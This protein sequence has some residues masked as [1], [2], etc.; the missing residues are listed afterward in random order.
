MIHGLITLVIVLVMYALKLP[1]ELYWLPVL[2]YL[3]REHAQ[4]EQRCISKYYGNQRINSP[5]YCGFEYRAW[6]IKSMFD[7]VIPLI[8]TVTT[9]Y[10]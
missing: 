1:N 7:W 2:F 6:N 4:A 9:V 10:L 3:G 8:I 5:W